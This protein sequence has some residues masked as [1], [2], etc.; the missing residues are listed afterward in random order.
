MEGRNGCFDAL[1]Q[2]VVKSFV[3]VHI[4]AFFVVDFYNTIKLFHVVLY[5]PLSGISL[6]QVYSPSSRSASKSPHIP[7]PPP[8]KRMQPPPPLP[9]KRTP[10][11]SPPLILT[12]APRSQGRHSG[13][14]FAGTRLLL[15]TT[16]RSSGITGIRTTHSR[17]G[18]RA[19]RK[20]RQ[21][22]C[23]RRIRKERIRV[24]E[25]IV[26]RPIKKVV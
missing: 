7:Y 26:L 6:T 25:N 1:Y 19:R 4:Y 14:L 10:R 2:A 5:N 8:F 3:V 15:S 9:H 20:N 18:A 22:S 23:R 17:I 16:R 24:L 12:H 11:P 13:R 21:R